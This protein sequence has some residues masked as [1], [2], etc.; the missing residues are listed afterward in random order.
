MVALARRETRCYGINL[1]HRFTPAARLAKH[2]VDEGRLGTSALRQYE[3]VDQESRGE[4]SLFSNQ[5]AASAHRGCDAPFLRRRRGRAVL[6]HES[7][8]PIDLEHRPFQHEIQERRGRRADRLVRHRARPSHGALRGRPAPAG[9]SCSTTCGAKLTLY[10]AGNL[11]K[12]VYTNPVFGGF[13]DFEDTFQDRIHAFLEQV[14]AGDAARADRRFGGRRPG[15]AEGARRR[16][17][18]AGN[19][20][21]SSTSNVSTA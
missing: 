17:R 9:G 6:R 19:T 7:A 1:N 18:I 20:R 16:D 15:G 14:T 4:L 8:G 10:P 21:P 2:W 5:G 11:E 13:R 12:T 3:H